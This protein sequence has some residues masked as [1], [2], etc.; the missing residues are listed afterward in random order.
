M[1]GSLT[2]TKDKF[3]DSDTRWIYIGVRCVLEVLHRL[4]IRHVLDIFSI[5]YRL[6]MNYLLISSFTHIFRHE[7]ALEAPHRLDIRTI[8]N[9]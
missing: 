4:E 2:L 5:H 8:H 1:V 9:I 6:L 7:G 3:L